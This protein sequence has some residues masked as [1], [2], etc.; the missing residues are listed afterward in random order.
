MSTA[1]VCE[2]KMPLWLALLG[3]RRVINTNH[4]APG[5]LGSPIQGGKMPRGTGVPPH[6]RQPLPFLIA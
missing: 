2:R 5:S 6:R 1:A 4:H 3:R